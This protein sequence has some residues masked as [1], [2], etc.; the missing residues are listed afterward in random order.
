MVIGNRRSVIGKR[1]GLLPDHRS[2]VTDPLLTFACAAGGPKQAVQKSFLPTPPAARLSLCFSVICYDIDWKIGADF[3]ISG[4][5]RPLPKV[6]ERL[7]AERLVSSRSTLHHSRAGSGCV[8][9]LLATPGRMSRRA[10]SSLSRGREPTVDGNIRAR[11]A[12]RR[13][14]WHATI[15]PPLRGFKTATPP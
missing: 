8:Q 13:K 6:F 9:L 10:A 12:Q 5:A 1:P 15:V 4:L 14:L 11:A 7:W 2:P 3:W